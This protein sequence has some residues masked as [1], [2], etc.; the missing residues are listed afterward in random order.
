MVSAVHMVKVIFSEQMM[1]CYGHMVRTDPW[2][3][4]KEISPKIYKFWLLFEEE[5]VILIYG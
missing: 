4:D 5:W 1:T 2:E 3:I